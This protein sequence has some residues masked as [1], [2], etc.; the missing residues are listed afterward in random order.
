M[1]LKELFPDGFDVDVE[2]AT[3]ELTE[4]YNKWRT[5]NPYRPFRVYHLKLILFLGLQILEWTAQ[6]TVA[7]EFWNDDKK[8]E[9]RHRIT[10]G[11]ILA[12]MFL[13]WFVVAYVMTRG[14]QL[15]VN[16]CPDFH[17]CHWFIFPM[18]LL[19]NFVGY[20]LV[21]L[22]ITF[23]R[24]V[25]EILRYIYFLV[26]EWVTQ[27][28]NEEE[29]SFEKDLFIPPYRMRSYIFFRGVF[30]CAFGSFP[31]LVV[32]LYSVYRDFDDSSD[33]K[34]LTTAC[35]VMTTISLIANLIKILRFRKKTK[36]SIWRPATHALIAFRKHGWNEAS[37]ISSNITASCTIEEFPWVDFYHDVYTSVTLKPV[38]NDSLQY[39]R[40]VCRLAARTWQL[41][42]FIASDISIA[43]DG[44]LMVG[45][46]T[47]AMRKNHGLKHL[48]LSHNIISN[49]GAV[50]LSELIGHSTTLTALDISHNK[51]AE[52]G[53]S[54]LSNALKINISI[55]ML[56]VSC[57][58]FGPSSGTDVGNVLRLNYTLTDLRL[59]QCQITDSSIKGLIKGLRVNKTLKKL[60]LRHNKIGP[61]GME[62][63]SRALVENNS[64]EQLALEGNPIG[65]QGVEH[66][67]TI[68]PHN[69]S[70]FTIELVGNGI[71]DRGA[72]ALGEFL[73]RSEILQYLYLSSNTISDSGM[74][75]IANGLEKSRVIIHLSLVCNLIGN[76]GARCLAEALKKN[77]SLTELHLGGN[78]ITDEG[79]CALAEALTVNTSLKI[80]TL[81]NNPFGEEGA[82]VLCDVLRAHSQLETLMIDGNCISKTT[83]ERLLSLRSENNQFRVSIRQ[84]VAEAGQLTVVSTDSMIRIPLGIAAAAVAQ[85]SE[86]VETNEQPDIPV[87][88]SRFDDE[89]RTTWLAKENVTLGMEDEVELGLSTKH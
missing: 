24:F 65:D 21:D 54:F 26:E 27:G 40:N 42:Q 10:A 23:S 61:Q 76:Q 14:T 19:Y 15:P 46:I 83:I 84:R 78:Q 49:R 36:L 67:S 44:P 28:P 71:T 11:F 53:F 3:E 73:W 57:S 16:P 64:L 47:E 43:D 38:P 89:L 39:F 82:G 2:K 1:T 70:L 59:N 30:Q 68:F 58:L 22:Y 17:L 55:N 25:V 6:A 69:N 5:E 8:D 7:G 75:A 37:K 74:M 52:E 79:V 85:N 35:M 66:L 50:P 63:L 13:P 4:R 48:D 33:S 12:F 34:E 60:W 88:K 72:L 81:E 45:H 20:A 31:N 29:L 9:T 51:I 56:D 80:L 87:M 18:M 41:Q 86:A 32:V 77:K 62:V